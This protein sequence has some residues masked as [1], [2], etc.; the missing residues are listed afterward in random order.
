MTLGKG[1]NFAEC[2]PCSTRQ[3]FNLC[4]VP[5]ETLGKEPTR[6]GPHVR[7]FVECSTRHLANLFVCITNISIISLYHKFQFA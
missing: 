6:K 2:L 1:V 5:P 3:R 7:F 4:R